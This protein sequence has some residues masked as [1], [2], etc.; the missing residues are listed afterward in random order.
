VAAVF[1]TPDRVERLQIEITTGCNLACA[2]C[3]RTIAVADDRWVNRSMRVAT[4]EKILE[5]APPARVLILQGIGEPTLHPDLERLIRLARATGRYDVVSF[6]T[7]ALL[8]G[9]DD[10]VA[11][12]RAGLGH[13]SVSVDSLRQETATHL[14]A[15]TDVRR[16]ETMI[17]ALAR[18]FPGMTL[19]IVLSRR[20]LGELEDL[21]HRLWRLGGRFVE[22]Q[23]LISYAAGSDPFTL[24]ERDAAEAR[25]IVARVRTAHPDFV[26]MP[27][28]A[29][30]PDGRRCRR[31][32]HAVYVTV[33][34]F[35][36]PCCTTNDVD[37]F[38]R[39]SLV[40]T[41]FAEAWEAAGPQRWLDRFFDRD[42]EICRGCAFNSAGRGAVDGD[43]RAAR[44]LHEA[45]RTAEAETALRTAA[46]APELVE[47]LH[48][49]GL[50]L[51]EKPAEAD[52]AA[53]L[54]L[55]ETTTVLSDEP[56]WSHNHALILARHGHRD[57]A[58]ARLRGL[59]AAHPEYV[60]TYRSL[61]QLLDRADDPVAAA[62]VLAALVE[63]ALDAGAEETLTGAIAAL[64]DARADPRNLIFL[65]NRLRMAGHEGEASLLL[66]RRLARAPDDLAAR[67]TRTM[68][69]L[70]VVHRD[71]AEIEARRAAYT[72]DLA[73][74]ARRVAAAGPAERA[75]AQGVIGAAK[76]FFLSY[77]GRDDRALQ[78]VYGDV[79]AALTEARRVVLPAPPVGERLR[80][81]FVTYYFTLHSVSKLFAG[82]M[83]HLDRSGFE[84]FGYNL[85][86]AA[87]ATSQRIAGTCERW[88]QE[89][90]SIDE[91]IAAIR[92][93]APHVL[94]YLELG[95][96]DLAIRLATHRLAPVQCQTWG[97]P[98]TSGLHDIDWFLS[99]DLMEPEDGAEHYRERLLRLPNLSIAYAP[100]DTV[101]GRLDRGELGLPADAVVYVCCQS[102]FKYLPEDDDVLVRIA[103]A[104]PTARFLFIAGD[105]RPP[106][107]IFRQRLEAAF[108]AGGLD[109]ARHLVFTGGVP[110]ERFHSLLQCGD[111]YLDSIGW[112][113]GNTTL[114]AVAAGLPVVTLPTGLMRGRHSRAILTRLGLPE[115]IADSR[116]DYVAR[117]VGL[118]DPAARA[119]AKARLA[120]RLPRLYHD[121]EP[122]RAL[123]RFF[124]EAVAE[125]VGGERAGG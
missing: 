33:D 43:F 94:V 84:V 17:T 78:A 56:R 82:W 23:P 77:Q 42:D 51:A 72:A 52:V 91:W 80:I 75:A 102:L 26:V 109:P 70:A 44:A 39:T 38:G 120:E 69:D 76:P 18:I 48:R 59:L 119:A 112:S 37:L 20:N 90:R 100:L 108:R 16:L 7:N 85:S 27:A 36:T 28:A 19:S 96:S 101:G 60:P 65:A 114:E 93:D 8:R 73:D 106:T 15:G 2:G 110:F 14:R 86:G 32:F 66:D 118:A 40:E 35:L 45:G 89:A 25:A 121:M 63:R 113:G 115:G 125:A 30:T 10:Y 79:V 74:L 116:D 50:I 3:Q 21:L 61:A 95:M 47:G 99:S 24:G 104:V 53:G 111:V 9:V 1:A 88:H 123:E 31:P 98:V 97:H 49:L 87:D 64:A 81:G 6:N 12:A 11:L 29:L 58:I 103:R 62:D 92:A 41:A 71:T 5:H 34:G 67:F 68:A 117:A 22:I 54:A 13:L 105:R 122:V 124:R 4:F 55:L 57:A 46:G 83:E 107:V